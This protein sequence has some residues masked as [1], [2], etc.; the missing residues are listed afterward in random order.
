MSTNTGILDVSHCHWNNLVWELHLVA[1]P[2]D[3]STDTQAAS[4]YKQSAWWH[5]LNYFLLVSG[6]LRSNR[7]C[8]KCTAQV[9]VSYRLYTVFSTDGSVPHWCHYEY[10]RS[11]GIRLWLTC[12]LSK[13]T[14]WGQDDIFKCIP[15]NKHVCIWIKISLTFVPKG[16][17]NNIPVLV[18]I[19]AW[20]QPGDKSLSEPM[21]VSPPMHMSITW[22]QWVK[23]WCRHRAN[24]SKV[25]ISV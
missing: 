16:P 22:P 8:T 19:M 11:V 24:K 20:L 12:I 2:L 7:S 3:N 5:P 21:M 25:I 17:I 4:V 1:C 9:G 15:W 18:Q 6:S 13:L 14:H 23:W 10:S